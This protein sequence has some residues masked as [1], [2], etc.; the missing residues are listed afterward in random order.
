MYRKIN[1]GGRK[2]KIT[3]EVVAKLEDAFVWGHSDSEACL[4]VGIDQA[5]LYRY[6][7]K[8]RSFATKKELLKN[9]PTLEARRT[10]VAA[11]KIDPDLA[12]K[13]LERKKKDEFALRQEYTGA[14]GKDL[15]PVPIMEVDPNVSSNNSNQKDM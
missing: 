8:H 6:C 1:K 15:I 11:I 7:E 5:T 12:L 9:T 3:P 4:I 14:G 2:P 13:Y 10:L